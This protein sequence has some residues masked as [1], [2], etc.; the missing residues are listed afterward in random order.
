MG[1]IFHDLLLSTWWGW[2]GLAAFGVFTTL[3]IGS[4]QEDSVKVV[5][6]ILAFA[7]LTAFLSPV[8]L[9]AARKGHK[10]VPTVCIWTGFWFLSGLATFFFWYFAWADTALGDS[11]DRILNVVPA[12]TAIVAAGLGWYV[13]Y[14]F[15]ARTQRINA[16]FALIMEMMK[17]SEYLKY[18][19]IVSQ[20]FPSSSPNA[21]ADYREYFPVS[22]RRDI[23]KKARD[24]NKIPDAQE[25]ERA[26]A[27][28]AL[29]YILNFYEFMAAGVR[30][31]DLDC[32][33][34][35]QTVCEVVIGR[36]ERALPLV[37]YCRTKGGAGG[38]GQVLAFE[39]LEVIVRD[40][41]HRVEDEITARKR[42]G[43]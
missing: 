8:I 26:E 32:D 14:Q 36:F 5:F 37:E 38:K 40:W 16:S 39:H 34:L 35:Q 19:R 31:N 10:S 15:T 28:G 21:V 2:C 13:H 1:K 7:S 33:L 27:I 43:G 3:A 24:E 41:S 30:S 6:A 11:S 42:N 22:S 18:S 4:A 23:E 20:H 12:L 25:L 9:R 29:R 17:S